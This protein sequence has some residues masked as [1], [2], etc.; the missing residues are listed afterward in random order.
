MEEINELKAGLIIKTNWGDH[1]IIDKVN[2]D[3]VLIQW[4]ENRIY[5]STGTLASMPK[6]K[7][8][9]NTKNPVWNLKHISIA[10]Q[11]YKWKMKKFKQGLLV[12]RKKDIEINNP[13]NPNQ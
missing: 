12:V 7:V 3:H 8:Y 5:W 4:P 9:F 10:D 1:G 11:N 13:P 6:K 2:S